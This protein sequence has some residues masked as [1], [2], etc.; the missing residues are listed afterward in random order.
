MEDSMRLI[1]LNRM[2]EVFAELY[3]RD[4]S[5]SFDQLNLRTIDDFLSFLTNSIQGN[6]SIDISNTSKTS[7]NAFDGKWRNKTE[8]DI[9]IALI[10]QD[11]YNEFFSDSSFLLK[12][13]IF[14]SQNDDSIE[15][16][17]QMENIDIDL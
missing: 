3:K 7:V 1:E 12:R 9:S 17:V 4:G 5:S 16:F 2:F 8:I 15:S 14:E 6:E 13:L 11:Q 10:G